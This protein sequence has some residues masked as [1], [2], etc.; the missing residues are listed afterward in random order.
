M[1]RRRD[2]LGVDSQAWVTRRSLEFVL[3]HGSK[4][5]F[6][7]VALGP[8]GHIDSS[9]VV[10]TMVAAV[11]VVVVAMVMVRWWDVG[12]GDH[13]KSSADTGGGNKMMVTV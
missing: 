1:R 8:G 5:F 2:H 13:S 4:A 12:D 7:V 6:R 9:G 10:V 3:D 11:V